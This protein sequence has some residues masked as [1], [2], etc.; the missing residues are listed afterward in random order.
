[1]SFEDKSS[2]SDWPSLLIELECKL[3]EHFSISVYERCLYY[4]LLTITRA[5]GRIE[6]TIS[7]RQLASALGCS[8]HSV[9]K[10]LR[11]LSA[12]G[13]IVADQTRRGF[14]VSVKLP[15]DLGIHKCRTEEDYIDIEKLD[16]F[17]NRKYLSVLL[18]REN[19]QCFYC[20]KT[21]A[22]ETCEL[23]HVIPLVNHGDNSYK[24]VVA[25]CHSCNSR[26][27]G[28]A[29]EQFLRQLYRSNLLSEEEFTDR[30]SALE[31]LKDGRLVPIIEQ[32]ERMGP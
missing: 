5:R 16:F 6:T 1:M 30:L 31:L 29:A 25:T 22:E 7:L 24:N 4:Q 13:V 15:N 19:S 12:K 8:E 14:N 9:R 10:Y 18:I 32:T 28:T 17:S 3:F 26:K 20:L 27:Q 2:V 21:I 23:D 11:S